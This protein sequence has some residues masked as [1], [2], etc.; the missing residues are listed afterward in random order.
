MCWYLNTIR[1][2]PSS[3]A[4]T[5]LSHKRSLPKLLSS[6]V[7][8]FSNVRKEQKCHELK[9]MFNAF[10]SRLFDGVEVFPCV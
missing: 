7:V 4:V 3:N 9:F 2:Q 10:S 1:L 5:I 6:S 8:N